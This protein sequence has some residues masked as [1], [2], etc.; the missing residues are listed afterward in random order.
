M[1][2]FL[3][4]NK[5]DLQEINLIEFVQENVNT[6]ITEEDIEQYKDVLDDLTLNVDNSSR[7]M[8]K[9]N[10]PSL[11]A[12]VAYSFKQDI[13]LDDWIVQYFNENDNYI[14]NQKENY[15]HSKECL[16]KFMKGMVA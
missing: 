1:Y 7:L 8:D 15:L 11:V 6:E 13:D 10:I 14:L 9:Q 16:D 4:I 12:I 3:H 2:E 5:E